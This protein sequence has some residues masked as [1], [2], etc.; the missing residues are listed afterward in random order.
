MSTNT[1]YIS[2]RAPQQQLS[3][4]VT[5]LTKSHQKR[6][7]QDLAELRRQLNEVRIGW[8]RCNKGER[9]KTLGMMYKITNGLVAILPT[10]ISIELYDASVTLQ[11][12][13]FT[14]GQFP[15]GTASPPTSLTAPHWLH[16]RACCCHHIVQTLRLLRLRDI[17]T[18]KFADYELALEE[19]VGS[20][21]SSVRPQAA[22]DLI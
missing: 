16:S 18:R 1:K 19:R 10:H 17:P 14:Q 6:L 15:S 5:I 12:M 3:R 7:Q 11:S 13:H 4:S 8:R 2:W 21:A 9:W 20:V 22:F